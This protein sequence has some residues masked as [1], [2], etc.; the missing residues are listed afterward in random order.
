M[1]K[2]KRWFW[3][4]RFY[5]NIVVCSDR[6]MSRH[7]VVIIESMSPTYFTKLNLAVVSWFIEP[8]WIT[9]C[10]NSLITIGI[11]V[12]SIILY[13]N[14]IRLIFL[15]DPTYSVVRRNLESFSKKKSRWLWSKKCDAKIFSNE[16][17]VEIKENLYKV[18][19]TKEAWAQIGKI[20]G[21]ITKKVLC[22]SR[23][24]NLNVRGTCLWTRLTIFE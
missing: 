5:R 21:I 9:H 12:P 18:S 23:L 15:F 16:F 4:F 24:P 10:R 22:L 20:G 8:S 13:A 17:H 11:T 3:S 7:A 14:C 2:G 19:E 1:R 6:M